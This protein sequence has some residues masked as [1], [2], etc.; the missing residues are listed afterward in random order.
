MTSYTIQKRVQINVN[1]I[2]PLKAPSNELLNH[3]NKGVLWKI[4][5]HQNIVGVIFHKEILTFFVLVLLKK[6]QCRLDNVYKNLDLVN[7]Q[8]GVSYKK[9]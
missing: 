2:V 9:V 7:P 4:K 8:H 6:L 5:E 3:F 1:I